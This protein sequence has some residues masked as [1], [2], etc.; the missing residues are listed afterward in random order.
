MDH[1]GGSQERG[2]GHS[3]EQWRKCGIQGMLEA[4]LKDVKIAEHALL[5]RG[6]DVV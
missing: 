4:R 5:D 2:H 1:H 3:D 6:H